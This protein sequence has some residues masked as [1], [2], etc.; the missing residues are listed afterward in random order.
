MGLDDLVG[1]IE[2]LKERMRSYRAA[3][4]ENETR[5]RMALIDPLLC[6]LGWDVSDPGVVAPEYRVGGGW[7]DYALLRPDGEPAATLE[8]KKLGES[9]VAHRMQM[10]NYANMAGIKYAGL[11]DGNHWELYKVLEPGRLEDRQILEVSIADAPAHESVLKLLLLW[12]PNLTSGQPVAAN[13][14]VVENHPLAPTPTQVEQASTPPAA[15]SDWVAL[16][17]YNP[18]PGQRSPCQRHGEM[19]RFRQ[20]KMSHFLHVK[21]LQPGWLPRS[22]LAV[23]LLHRDTEHPRLALGLE[24]ELSPLMLIVVEW[25]NR[26]SRIAVANTASLKMSPQSTKLLLLVRITEAFS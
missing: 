7:A 17:E 18:P 9:L 13:T 16:S 5:T 12:R 3:L 11:T 23:L 24:P 22:S 19:S 15:A 20:D 10:L 21:R 1:C 2:V 6:A 26:R 4:E 8:A 25:C 14:P